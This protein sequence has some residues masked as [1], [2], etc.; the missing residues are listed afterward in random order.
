MA[1]TTPRVGI[2]GAGITG[3]ALSY[4]LDDRGVDHV[5]LESGDEPGGIIRSSTVDGK[6]LEHGPQRTRLTGPIETF[7]DALDLHDAT[8]TADPTLPMYV[9]A[10]GKLRTVPFSI[11]KFFTTDLLSWRGKLR[12]LT[13]PLTKPGREDETAAELFTRK[14]GEEAYRNFIGPLFGG[15]YGS[16]PAEMPAGYAPS[17]ILALERRSGSL[18]RPALETALE[19]ERHPPLNFEEGLQ[20]LPRAIYREVEDRVHF[21]RP[22]TGI[23]QAAD[24]YVIAT[25][26]G[27]ELVDRVV[28]TTPADVSADVLA[29]LAPDAADRLDRLNYN[30]LAVVHLYAETDH[31]GFGY[32][33][34]RD[35]DLHTLGVSW[36]A[37][38]F[39]RDGVYT[40]F[41][42][43]M[44]EPELVEADDERLG[45]IATEEFEAVMGDPAEVIDITR[46]HRGFPAW[47][48]SWTATDDLE[49]P[50]GIHLATNYTAR[51]GIPSRLR[52]AGEL[53]E[54]FAEERE[55]RTEAAPS[56]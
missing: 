20:Q 49:F 5:V 39:D 41:L 33:V 22:V 37:K 38:L 6:V 51:M 10:N 42:G 2:V 9:Y 34:R 15:I 24:G 30:P 55:E 43:G 35:E 11:T 46:L 48:H 44:D 4:H 32:Q 12:V 50:D 25:E 56:V 36:N 31:E 23:H 26:D 53:A 54:T 45:S 17:P 8:I 27:D 7:V 47:D 19:N 52:E 1:G 21:E 14:F 13:E 3:L 40:A 28:L 29:D 16:D 18:L